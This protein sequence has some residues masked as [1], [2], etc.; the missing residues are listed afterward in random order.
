MIIQLFQ[1]DHQN[2]EFDGGYVIEPLSAGPVLIQNSEGKWLLVDPGA[3]SHKEKLLAELAFRGLVPADID[4]VLN[5]HHHLD[6]ASNN[7][8]F[9]DYCP[10]FTR[11]SILWPGGKVT[12]YRGSDAHRAQWPADVELVD[13]PGHTDD[14]V[15][16]VYREDGV[17]YVC[18]GDAVREDIIR[19]QE[20]VSAHQKGDFEKSL[21]KIFEIGDVIFPGHGKV[22]E[23]KLF[24][25][26]KKLL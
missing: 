1:G 11:S 16:F 13:T 23:G 22:I 18:A 14:H 15:S 3:F 21:K 12:I 20:S 19:G 5:T 7:F 6:H 4:A 2:K 8:I 26:L 10:I 17:N 25:E 24:E 9:H